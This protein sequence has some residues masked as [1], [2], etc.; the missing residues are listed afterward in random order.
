MKRVLLE[1]LREVDVVHV[2]SVHSVFTVSTGLMT[3]NSAC[4]V[5]VVVTPHYHGTGHTVLRRLLWLV[6]RRKVSELLSKANVVHAVSG[7]E[8]ALISKHY[9]HVKKSYCDP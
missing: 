1:L 7:E 3:A 4:D 6:W 5:K 9:P 8:R 2:H